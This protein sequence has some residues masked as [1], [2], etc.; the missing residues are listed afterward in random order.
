MADAHKQLS[1]FKQNKKSEKF[2]NDNKKIGLSFFQKRSLAF[3]IDLLI[4]K[5]IVQVLMS[6]AL[7]YFFQV[8]YKL[9]REVRREFWFTLWRTETAFTAIAFWGYYVIAHYWGNGHGIGK[10]AMGLRLVPNKIGQ[11]SLRSLCLRSTIYTLSLFLFPP[12]LLLPLFLKEKKSLAD[13]VLN[14]NVLL[15]KDFLHN[16]SLHT[17]SGKIWEHSSGQLTLDLEVFEI[18]KVTLEA[19]EIVCPLVELVKQH[20]LGQ[21]ED[22]KIAA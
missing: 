1:L 7:T 9:P 16:R 20:E 14:Q 12:I 21:S 19:K 6:P 3:L 2:I 5:A 15:E 13:F 10:L 11:L 22:K 8:S 18:P 4:V 17:Q